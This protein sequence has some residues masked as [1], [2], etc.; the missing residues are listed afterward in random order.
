M[1]M[2]FTYAYSKENDEIDIAKKTPVAEVIEINE[3]KNTPQPHIK[4]SK[5]EDKTQIKNVTEYKKP[6]ESF[7]E[8]AKDFNIM[9]M[10]PPLDPCFE[11][12]E[13]V[14][15]QGDL[16]TFKALGD[17][18]MLDGA[19]KLDHSHKTYF[20]II[21]LLIRDDKNTIS[22]IRKK[23]LTTCRQLTKVR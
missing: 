23:L 2:I 11:A 9:K 3:T 13:F 4:A 14:R 7:P 20:G 10:M 8:L 12:V 16:S 15:D 22:D 17:K 19:A 18:I 1:S 21:G 5:Q 6:A